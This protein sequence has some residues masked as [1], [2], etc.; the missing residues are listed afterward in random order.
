MTPSGWHDA[1]VTDA[2]RILSELIGRDEPL[3]RLRDVLERDGTA[4][5]TGE[6]GIG[7]TTLLRAA[8]AA[9]GRRAYEG[10][11]LA[12]LAW[13]PY[14]ALERA[15]NLALEGDADWVADAVERIVGPDV[16]LVDDLQSVDAGT[17]AVLGRLVGRIAILAATRID[18]DVGRA[19]ADALTDAGAERLDLTPLPPDAALALVDGLGRDVPDARRQRIVERAAGNPLLL[20]QLTLGGETESLRRAVAAR[21]GALEPADRAVLALIALAERPVPADAL[22]GRGSRLVASGFAAERP[23]GVTIRHTLLADA[24]LAATDA[25]TTIRL[26]ERLAELATVPGERARHLAAAGRRADAHTAALEAVAAAS[27]VGERAAHLG[28]AATTA[29][30]ADADGLRVD[31]AAALRIAGDLDG[32]TVALDGLEGDDPETRAR[33]EAIR[34]RVRWSAGDPD[35]MRAAIERGLALVDRTGSVAEAMLRSEEVVVTALVDGHFEDGLRDAAVAVELAEAAGAD[36]TRPLLLRATLLA[37]LGLD[38]WDAALEAVVAAA[39]ARGDA[40]TELSAANNLVAGH[41]MHGDHAV[42][43]SVATAMLGRAHEL[44]LAT[45]GRQFTAMLVNLDLHAGDLDAA[46][47]RGE[48]LLE[49]PLDPL[50]AGQVGLAVACALVDLGRAEEAG[51]RLER[52]LA[53]APDDAVARLGVLHI[54]AEHELWAGRPTA[55]LRRVE[56]IRALD[57]GDHPTAHLVDVVA[58]WAAVDAA[59]PLPARVATGEPEGMLAGASAERDATDALAGGDDRRAAD[60]FAGAAQAYEG[61]HRRG[62]LRA[63]WAAAE[64]RRR[65][66]DADTARAALEALEVEASEQGFGPL[67]GRIRRSLRLAGARRAAGGGGVGA[68]SAAS[69]PPSTGPRLTQREREIVGLVAGGASNVEIARRL[70]VGRP[71][72]ARLLSSAMDKLGVDSRGQVAAHADAD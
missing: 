14:L 34:A 60:G 49:E 19:A 45:W 36:V 24:V 26:H 50:A 65:N 41:E 4:V 11:G 29:A 72:V 66:G 21:L 39:R 15:T 27:S 40:E 16:L 23:D 55:A 28:V 1:R 32:A 51:A 2:V 61:V 31:A 18:D 67:T 59:A 38:G 6:P 54:A 7:K 43:R 25:A 46:V 47:E 62:E 64:A 44:R 10:G 57:A 71:T 42:A 8:A 33:A 53:D 35:G 13:Q 56:D 68:S 37:G 58:G 30:G 17:V 48:A 63:R 3:R 52:L 70:G 69:A 9:T 22:E 20:E 12:I 5:V